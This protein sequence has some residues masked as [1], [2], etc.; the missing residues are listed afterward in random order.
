MGGL[1]QLG[2]D[3]GSTRQRLQARLGMPASQRLLRNL[4]AKP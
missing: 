4:L 2:W 3:L 1:R